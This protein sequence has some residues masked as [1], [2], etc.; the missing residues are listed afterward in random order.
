[1]TPLDKPLRREL[2]IGDQAYTLVIDPEGMTL[3]EKG[4]RKGV[5]LRWDELVSGDAAVARA[6]Q[7]S[8]E[9]R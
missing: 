6:L 7:A 5:R 1:M 8:L 3:M 2:H 4:R 9:D